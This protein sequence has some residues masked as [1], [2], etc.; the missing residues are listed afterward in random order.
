LV[1]LIEICPH[2]CPD[3]VDMGSIILVISTNGVAAGVRVCID[4]IRIRKS[5]NAR[6]TIALEFVA[7]TNRE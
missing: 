3:A 5:L 2:F 1:N 4:R 7:K 6:A